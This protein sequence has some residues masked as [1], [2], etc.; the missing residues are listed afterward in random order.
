MEGD[1]IIQWYIQDQ[2]AKV[3]R[4]VKQ[5][6]GFNRVTI[7]PGTSI[8]VE[9]TISLD[10]LAY[11]H[12]DGSHSADD[13]YFTLFVGPSSTE[14]LSAE[15]A[16]NRVVKEIQHEHDDEKTSTSAR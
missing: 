1:E 13:G 10:M 11:L 6:K 14:G 2:V 9:L 8:E 12:P 4:P 3:S 7:A 15:F 5:L 16:L